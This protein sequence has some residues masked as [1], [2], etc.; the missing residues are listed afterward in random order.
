[1]EKEQVHYL[2]SLAYAEEIKNTE[3]QEALLNAAD[4][5]EGLKEYS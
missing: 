1:M 2:R 4:T 5:I 3:I